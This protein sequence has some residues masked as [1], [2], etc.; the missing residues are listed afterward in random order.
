ML[1]HKRI[2]TVPKETVDN[3][4]SKLEGDIIKEIDFDILA[5]E[6]SK[7]GWSK[8]DLPPFD[9]QYKVVDIVDW[10]FHHCQGS[11]EHFGMRF[12]FEEKQDATLFAL[13]WL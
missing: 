4:M 5:E 9:N 13:K 1:M 7:H 3:I 6:L 10:A 8:V 11:F 2:T 12:I